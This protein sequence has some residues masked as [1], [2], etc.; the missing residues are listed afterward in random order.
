MRLFLIIALFGAISAS[1][2]Q[3]NCWNN[4]YA[5]GVGSIDQR[6]G[7]Y[8]FGL[9]AQFQLFSS[10][11]GQIIDYGLQPVYNNHQKMTIFLRFDDNECQNINGRISC[12]AQASQNYS[13]NN[14][15]VMRSIN[16]FDE[17]IT[18]ISRIFNDRI[19]VSFDGEV[20]TA[21]IYDNNGQDFLVAQI[22]MKTCS[23]DGQR[24]GTHFGNAFFPQRLRDYLAE[25]N[26]RSP[27]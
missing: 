24:G 10:H 8:E 2:T 1:A 17:T 3:Y 18:P 14:A 23:L 12:E 26:T 4:T 19:K 15:W 27:F 11:G 5:Y 7:K 13:S 9:K 22:E 21:E 6:D 16:D 25:H 20:L